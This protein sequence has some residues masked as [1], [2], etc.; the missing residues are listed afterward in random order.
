MCIMSIFLPLAVRRSVSYEVGHQDVRGV[1]DR[2][3][4]AGGQKEG[5]GLG[6]H[7]RGHRGAG[8]PGVLPAVAAGPGET[9]Q[10][11]GTGEPGHEY[12]LKII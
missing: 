6:G 10:T 2:A 3:A 7:Q 11:G 9:G 8:G 5:D 1:V 4:D 12:S